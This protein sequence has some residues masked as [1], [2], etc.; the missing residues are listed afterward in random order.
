MTSKISVCE[1]Y[2]TLKELADVV[3]SIDVRIDDIEA[4]KIVPITNEETLAHVSPCLLYAFCC[5]ITNIMFNEYKKRLAPSPSMRFGEV[6]CEGS[7]S[8]FVWFK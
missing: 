8:K 3:I 4:A 6:H 5:F 1:E 7:G 2:D